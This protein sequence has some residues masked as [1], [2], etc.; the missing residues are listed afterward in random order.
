MCL[1][2]P[3][4]LRFRKWNFNSYSI[5]FFLK[6]KEIGKMTFGSGGVFHLTWNY[7]LRFTFLCK[8]SCPYIPH[9][10]QQRVSQA[11]VLWISCIGVQRCNAHARL[12]RKN[13]RDPAYVVMSSLII[14]KKS[15]ISFRQQRAQY[16]YCSY[17]YKVTHTINNE[18][19]NHFGLNIF[20]TTAQTCRAV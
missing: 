16:V 10:F 19:V 20:F 8:V 7:L 11:A 14:F 4:F 2:Q 15:G 12:G 1:K 18:D 5:G 9:P 13:W 6:K 17:A 3:L